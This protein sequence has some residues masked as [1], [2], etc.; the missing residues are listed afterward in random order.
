MSLHKDRLAVA[1]SSSINSR[2]ISTWRF[3]KSFFVLL[4]GHSGKQPGDLVPC[5]KHH[6]VSEVNRIA[7][8]L[9]ILRSEAWRWLWLQLRNWDRF[10]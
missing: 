7:E 10:S 4:K 6:I 9:M 3:G 8:G 1:C 5:S 2:G